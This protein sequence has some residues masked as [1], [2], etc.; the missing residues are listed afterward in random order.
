MT[1]PACK[2]DAPSNGVGPSPRFCPNCGGP[3]SEAQAVV[4]EP[5]TP[6]NAAALILALL[7]IGLFVFVGLKATGFLSERPSFSMPS[8][9]LNTVNTADLRSKVSMGMTY[10]A[11]RAAI[12]EPE[13]VQKMEGANDFAGTTIKTDMQM[14]YYGGTALQIVFDKGK[15]TGA[16]QY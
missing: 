14:W 15:V 16:N 8:L 6:A 1:C 7:M 4:Q 10:G 11:V 13:R 3:L 5:S 12:G 9:G 2:H